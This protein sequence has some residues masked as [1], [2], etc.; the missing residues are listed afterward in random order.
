MGA[1]KTNEE[2]TW[3]DTEKVVQ[4]LFQEKLGFSDAIHY[5][6]ITDDL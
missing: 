3:E 6:I 5:N 2:K 4:K 1:E